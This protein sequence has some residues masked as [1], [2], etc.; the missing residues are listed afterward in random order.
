MTGDLRTAHLGART[1]SVQ[2]RAELAHNFTNSCRV[3]T[4]GACGVPRSRRLRDTTGPTLQSSKTSGGLTTS[5][6][7]PQTTSATV[8]PTS[9]TQTGERLR[10]SR[11]PSSQESGRSFPLTLKWFNIHT[12]WYVNCSREEAKGR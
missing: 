2:L 1:I 7:D 8:S 5:W 10:N 6:D 4:E 3:R 9:H 11:T 12:G